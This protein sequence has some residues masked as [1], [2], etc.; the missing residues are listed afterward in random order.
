VAQRLAWIRGQYQRGGRDTAG[1]FA[2]QPYEQL[3]ALYRQ[4]GQDTQARAVAIARRADLRRY[5]NLKWYRRTGNWLLE[6]TIRYGYQT[7]R[8]GI[9]LAAVFVAVWMLAG[10]AQHL[11]MIV[12]VGN[13]QGLHPPPSAT[14]CT[15][16]YPCFYPAGYAIDTVIPIIHVRQADYWGLDGHAPW[17]W[18][19]VTGTWIATGLGWALACQP[20]SS[21]AI[22]DSYVKTDARART[23]QA[24]CPLKR[25]AFCRSTS[26]PWFG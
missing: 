4:A 24:K 18:A 16:N 25:Q 21:Q 14:H 11:H 7:W 20:C 3:G 22:P 1:E 10:L 19:W 8:A 23:D 15:S 13:I 5:G 2:A 6:K 12:P 17:G 9:G 26:G